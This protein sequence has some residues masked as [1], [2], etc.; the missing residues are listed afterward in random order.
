MKTT[1]SRAWY[2]VTGLVID[3]QDI[4]FTDEKWFVLRPH[5][6]RQNYRYWSFT[7]PYQYDDSIKQR[8]EKVMCWAA[9]A[10]VRLLRLVWFEK[11]ESVNGQRYLDLLQQSLYP[12]VRH[13]A[14][15][16]EY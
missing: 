2:F 15:R 1:N 10:D 12:V 11:D 7:N 13:I 3:S 5:P 14:T 6:N 9:I 16:R 4:I 8:A